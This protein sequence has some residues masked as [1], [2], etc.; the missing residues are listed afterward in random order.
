MRT[1]MTLAVLLSLASTVLADGEPSA[2]CLAASHRVMA[3]V[4]EAARG[5]RH[6]KQIN[7]RREI[8]GGQ[9]KMIRHLAST[10]DEDKCAY[11]MTAPD[12]AMR[13]LALS[14]LPERNGE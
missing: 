4:D 11:L 8:A 12:S 1:V 10:L 13:A 5:T 6:E 14:M 2:I 7:Q 9:A 3:F